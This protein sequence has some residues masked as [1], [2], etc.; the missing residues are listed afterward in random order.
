MHSYQVT[1]DEE[2]AIE[3]SVKLPDEE[4]PRKRTL[5]V[6]ASTLSKAKAIAKELYSLAT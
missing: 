6:K 1:F 5:I 4:Q 2:G 3:Q